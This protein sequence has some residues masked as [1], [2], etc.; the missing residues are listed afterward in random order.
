M[1][2]EDVVGKMCLALAWCA[3]KQRH[4]ELEILF[5]GTVLELKLNK[6][7]LSSTG[8]KESRQ[9]R[10]IQAYCMLMF[11]TKSELLVVKANRW[12]IRINRIQDGL[13]FDY[14]WVWRDL[15]LMIDEKI[16][17]LIMVTEVNLTKQY[18][19]FY[20]SVQIW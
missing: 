19:Y 8:N 9:F 16:L 20:K 11:S 4:L 18:Q 15:N 7:Y 10:W 2:K 14:L 5:E 6:G 1:W 3:G 12:Q 17:I 13:D